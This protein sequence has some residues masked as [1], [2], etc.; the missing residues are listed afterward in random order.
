MEQGGDFLEDIWIE[1]KERKI[2]FMHLQ[3]R[4][5]YACRKALSRQ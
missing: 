2:L 5:R 4:Q 1:P 3:Y